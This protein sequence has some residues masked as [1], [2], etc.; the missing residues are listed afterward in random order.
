M[1]TLYDYYRSTA[2]YRIRIALN[3]KNLPHELKPVNLIQGEGEH[4]SAAYSQVNPQQLVPSMVDH[5]HSITLSQSLAILEYLEEQYPQP[6]ILP[7]DVSERAQAR[8]IAALIACDMHPLNNLRVLRYITNTLKHTEEEKLQWYHHWL[9]LG[10]DA[11]EQILQTQSNSHPY[12]IG[13]TVSIADICLI[14]QL[15]NARRFGFNLTQYP[16]I[17]AIETQCLTMPAFEKAKPDNQV[18]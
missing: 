4:R 8:R 10:F 16:L 7:Q 15:Y 13:D 9:Q 18:T 5:T 14:P 12:C 3:V 1:I 2:S 17:L 6:A 11:I